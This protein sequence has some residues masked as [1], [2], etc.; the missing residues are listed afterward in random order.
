M[1]W[2]VCECTGGKE[3]LTIPGHRNHSIGLGYTSH[4][5]TPWYVKDIIPK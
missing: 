4:Y 2:L 5:M 1:Y 3:L